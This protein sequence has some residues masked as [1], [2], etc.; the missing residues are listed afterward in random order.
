[1]SFSVLPYNINDFYIILLINMICFDFDCLF[2]NIF[3]TFMDEILLFLS[4]ENLKFL[5]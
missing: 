1:M 4:V 2:I 3:Y 5:T